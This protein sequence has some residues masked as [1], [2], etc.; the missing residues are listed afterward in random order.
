[1]GSKKKKNPN[2]FDNFHDG[3]EDVYKDNSVHSVEHWTEEEKIETAVQL[4]TLRNAGRWAH[5][6]KPAEY[7]INKEAAMDF[8]KANPDIQKIMTPRKL[9]TSTS[10]NIPPAEILNAAV[11]RWENKTSLTD[12]MFF[13]C[14]KQDKAEFTDPDG[15]WFEVHIAMRQFIN[16]THV[17][18]CNWDKQL[19]SLGYSKTT[20][21]ASK[22]YDLHIS[23]ISVDPK[24][25]S[26]D[27]CL[28]QPFI[29]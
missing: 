19:K 8:L 25:S 9:T 1:M 27:N 18:L 2:I 10:K 26:A 15:P 28:M 17:D 12:D 13:Y 5:V 21:F 4:A 3:Y 23:I 22:E 7:K 20:T 11:R 24:F 16:S 29:A 6:P 14:S